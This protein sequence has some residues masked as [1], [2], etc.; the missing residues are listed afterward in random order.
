MSENSSL[1]CGLCPHKCV[2]SSGKTGFCGTRKNVDGAIVSLSYGQ[3]TAL[4]V[5]PIEKKPLYHFYAGST[6]LSLGGFGC[7]MKCPFCQ[8]HDISQHG[9]EVSQGYVSPEKLVDIAHKATREARSIGVAFTYNEPFLS[10]EYIMDVAPLL[11]SAGQ[12]VV[13]VTNGQVLQE[14]LES[15]LPYVDA[16]N[17]DLKVFSEDGYK[18]MGGDF[19]T[20]KATIRSAVDAGVHVEVTT[21]VIPEIN[22]DPSMMRE[23]AQWLS[24]L[25]KDIPLHLSRYFPR[26]KLKTGATPVE[27]LHLLQDICREYLDYVYLGNV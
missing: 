10:Y 26:Y 2:L 17:I 19:A 16:M 12:K 23:E 5:D 22:D 24:E 6:I 8:N 20:A 1:I 25:G 21:L 18:W 14:P 3:V 4:A 7:N 9:I 15:L 27:T 11:K 13:L